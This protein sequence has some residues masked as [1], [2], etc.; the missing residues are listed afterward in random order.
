VVSH[1]VLGVFTTI[2]RFPFLFAV[3]FGDVGHGFLMILFA[4]VLIL[5]EKQ[6]SNMKWNE[7]Y[8]IVLLRIELFSYVD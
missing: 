2:L 4:V 5:K 8:F 7:V 6:L 3:M 1:Y